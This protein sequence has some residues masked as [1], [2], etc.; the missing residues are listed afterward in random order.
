M[1]TQD[2]VGR[3]AG[4]VW[5]VLNRKKSATFTELR[6]TTKLGNKEIYAALGWLA[7]ENK[8]KKDGSKYYL[9]QTNLTPEIGSNAGTVYKLLSARHDLS[10]KEI[11]AESKLKE[12]DAWHAIGWLAKENKVR[13]NEMGRFTLNE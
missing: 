5:D 2:E 7:R 4:K 12:S 1:T 9:D 11:V 3:Y 6:N 13:T 10:L 8:V